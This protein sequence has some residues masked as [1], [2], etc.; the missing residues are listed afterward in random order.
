MTF[1]G[2]GHSRAVLRSVPDV[3]LVAVDRDPVAFGFAQQLAGEY[4]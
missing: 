1:G 3:T 2:G 4:P